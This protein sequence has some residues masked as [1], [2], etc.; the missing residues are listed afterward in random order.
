MN[1]RDTSLALLALAALPIGARAQQPGRV[2]RIGYLGTDP[3]LSSEAWFQAMTKLGWI[4]G[5]NVV[6]EARYSEGRAERLPAL[7]AELVRL[8]V[9]VILAEA[10]PMTEAAKQATKTI[11]IVFVIHVDPVGSGH[12]ASMAR[13]GGNITG[14]TT[15]SAE[16]C[17]KRL[18][19]F[20]ELIPSASRIAVLWNAANPA[21]SADR[22]ATQD[23]ARA[24]AFD[25][26]SIEVRDPNDFEAAFDAI[27]RARPD[28]LMTLEDPLTYFRRV[29]V[30]EFAA[31]ARLPAIY[32]SPGYADI[33]GLMSYNVKGDE[34]MRLSAY[35][36]D[37]ILR[38]AKPADLPV[39]QPMI[40]S[41]EVNLK[42]AKA[43][44]LT[45]P[46]KILT[47]ADVVIG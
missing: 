38:G 32:G 6:I 3:R 47:R 2:Y 34:Y 45:M 8:N 40:F 20:K 33:G 10:A 9:D 16:L 43:L 5:Q 13:P 44:G 1:R 22:Q 17:G 30:V 21:K 28:G 15:M 46:S 7:A 18:Q 35:Y 39:Q 41:L 31:S 37:K 26:E 42:A 19:L 4:V 23:A 12:V 29:A 24:L 36:V 27:R 25:I 14:A 11:P